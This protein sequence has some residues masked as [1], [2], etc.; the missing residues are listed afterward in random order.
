VPDLPGCAATGDTVATVEREI[1]DTIRF[2]ID[3]LREHGLPVPQP[4]SLPEYV[5]A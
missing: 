4:T 5:E 2:H 3:G 1:G